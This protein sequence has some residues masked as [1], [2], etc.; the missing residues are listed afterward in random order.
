V[1]AALLAVPAALRSQPVESGPFRTP[2]LTELVRLDSTLRL[3]IRYAT[4]HNFMGRPMY[5]QARAFLQRPAAE[6]LVRAHRKLAKQGYGLLVF[7]GY[8]P[9]SV[10]K[11]FWDSMPPEK[12]S[13]V[14]N[15]KKGSRHNRGCAVD[16]SLYDRR[17]GREVP[18]PSAYDDFTDR[19][20]ADFPGGTGEQRR[21]R[22]VLRTAMEAEGFRV[23]AEEW[24][25]F[26]YRDWRE[27]PLLDVKFE[28]LP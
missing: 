13:Y 3:D 1:C 24:W 6:A 25:H 19:A 10:T 16:L 27:Y 9:W 12:R 18:M 28:E 26:D 15:P 23:N 11:D 2:D 14:A 4:P 21:A 8:R 17:T 7:D 22:T 20:A 5:T